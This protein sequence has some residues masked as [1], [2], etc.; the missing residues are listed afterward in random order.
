LI[1]GSKC[2]ILRAISLKILLA[3]A[4]A[5]ILSCSSQ[6]YV[7]DNENKV[8]FDRYK[9]NNFTPAADSIPLNQ[10]Q[11]YIRPW[12]NTEPGFR[13]LHDLHGSERIFRRDGFL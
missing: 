4:L 3:V 13:L 7:I 10:Y 6:S 1:H 5:G 8:N 12:R 9:T 2:F 11:Y